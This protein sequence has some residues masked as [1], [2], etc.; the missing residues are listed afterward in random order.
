M[1][2]DLAY[3]PDCERNVTVKHGVN[4]TLFV[5]LAFFFIV[6]AIIYLVWV[7]SRPKHCPI[8]KSTGVVLHREKEEEVARATTYKRQS[9]SGKRW[10]VVAGVSGA[11]LILVITPI[12]YTAMLTPEERAAR[13]AERAAEAA[14]I[15]ATPITAEQ[16]RDADIG[17]G[18]C[19]RLFAPH[20]TPEVIQ[21]CKDAHSDEI[22]DYRRENYFANRTGDN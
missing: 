19:I 12:V 14:A 22:H 6:P 21:S 4:V 15:E 20:I 13:E 5:V 3:C 10:L 16:Q 7:W 18:D 8:C 9:V 11:F 2:H 1:K 17:Y